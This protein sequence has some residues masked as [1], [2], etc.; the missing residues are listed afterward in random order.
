MQVCGYEVPQ[1]AIDAG[2]ARMKESTFR[3]RDI[4]AAVAPHVTKEAMRVADK[5]IQRHRR[6][7]DIVKTY[8]SPYWQWTGKPI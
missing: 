2:I 4:E 7:G 8:L 3:A 6:S 5:L 1:A